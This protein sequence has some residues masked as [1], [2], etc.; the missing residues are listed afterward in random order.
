MFAPVPSLK[1][2]HTS[3]SSSHSHSHSHSHSKDKGNKRK[4]TRV[5]RACSNCR[6]RKQGCEEERPCRRCVEKGIDCTEVEPKRKRG[7]SKSFADGRARSQDDFYDE[8]DEMEDSFESDS[9][10]SEEFS[11][12]EDSIS[13]RNSSHTSSSTSANGL[14]SHTF[15][16]NGSNT[17]SSSQLHSSPFVSSHSISLSNDN[18]N[19]HSLSNSNST[20]PTLKSRLRDATPPPS[21]PPDDNHDEA[22]AE[23]DDDMVPDNM[24]DDE[25]PYREPSSG[26]NL[27]LL[28]PFIGNICVSEDANTTPMAVDDF[29][30]PSSFEKDN[31]DSESG[32]TKLS[33]DVDSSDAIW[34][35]DMPFLTSSISGQPPNVAIEEGDSRIQM[36]VKECWEEFQTRSKTHNMEEDLQRVKDLWKEILRCSRSRD[37]QKVN[38]LLEEVES[39]PMDQ[40]FGEKVKPSVVFWSSG[41]RIHHANDTFCNMVGYSVQELQADASMDM[42]FGFFN[43][44]PGQT[45]RAHCLFHP[46]ELMKIMKR[47]LEAVQNPEKSAYQMNTRLVSKYRQEIPVSCSILNLR[48]TL[49]MSLL[50]VAIFI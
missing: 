4:A 25:P 21:S 31:S 30:Y 29:G 8:E 47:Q 15:K 42:N 17:S 3:S 7:R 26:L 14:S 5:Q 38:T 37:W 41:G 10:R 20:I 43:A 12:D 33:N 39:S 6:K 13:P 28:L 22:G 35:S 45:L 9:E 34:N 50:T 44:Y 1:H 23:A 24:Q 11:S 18:S 27:S 40:Y 36:Y 46:E 48:D 2:H 49:G 32:T 19:V 16:I